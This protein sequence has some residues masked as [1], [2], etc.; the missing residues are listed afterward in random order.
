M[1]TMLPRTNPSGFIARL[2]NAQGWL[3]FHCRQP[4]QKF[5]AINAADGILAAGYTKDHLVPKKLGGKNRGNIVLAHRWCNNRRGHQAPGPGAMQRA[6]EI[7]RR[8]R[9]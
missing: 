5:P 1:T 7:W 4:M 2:G 9:A 3:C 6:R 8:A